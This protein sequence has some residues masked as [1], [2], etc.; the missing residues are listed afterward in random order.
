MASPAEAQPRFRAM[1]AR[2]KVGGA[3]AA[4]RS[5]APVDPFASHAA[6]KRAAPGAARKSA[7]Q[8]A[9]PVVVRSA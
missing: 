4:A 6:R 2:F 5:Q 9:A 7:N 1:F 8:A 3:D